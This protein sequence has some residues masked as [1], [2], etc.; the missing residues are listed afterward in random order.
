MAGLLGLL[1]HKPRNLFDYDWTVC[2]SQAIM[3]YISAEKGRFPLYQT[4]DIDISHI[5]SKAISKKSKQHKIMYR[6]RLL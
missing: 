5:S 6:K 3:E 4:C 1:S 2:P